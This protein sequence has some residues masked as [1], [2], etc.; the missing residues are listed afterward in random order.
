[1]RACVSP[2]RDT[3]KC[4]AS[5]QASC[6]RCAD[7]AQ[8]SG[9]SGAPPGGDAVFEGA[10]QEEA[11]PVAARQQLQRRRA[12]HGVHRAPSG[13]RHASV[14]PAFHVVVWL[15]LMPGC[16]SCCARLLDQDV[17]VEEP[18]GVCGEKF[19]RDARR[20]AFASHRR[21]LRHVVAAEVLHKQPRVVR[22]ARDLRGG[23]GVRQ[24]VVDSSA[25]RGNLRR[26]EQPAHAHRA[27]A[28]PR[29]AQRGAHAAVALE[30][31]RR[32]VIGV[33]H[34]DAAGRGVRVRLSS[35][36]FSCCVHANVLL[37][38]RP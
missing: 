9:A 3:A 26:A 10:R 22:G 18:D 34:F 14:L 32:R 24:H 31:Q 21:K 16:G 13:G 37:T 17:V 2:Q 27:V 15:V 38:L 20:R 30:R 7:V 4:C 5:T 36:K 8:Q 11:L 19:T 29:G 23:R 12:R 25:H 33:S 35:A 6:I 1:M 28:R